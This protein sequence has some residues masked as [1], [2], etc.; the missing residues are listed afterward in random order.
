[1][2]VRNLK[3]NR[4]SGC[5]CAN[6]WWE[7]SPNDSNTNNFCNVNSDG[8]ANANNASNTNLLAPF[9]Y[10]SQTQTSSVSEVRVI[11]T[12]AGVPAPE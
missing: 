6:N 3:V 7:R 4:G 9:G 5:K 11:D 12:G 2:T 1:M 8:S 10:I